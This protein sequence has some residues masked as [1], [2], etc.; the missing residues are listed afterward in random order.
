MATTAIRPTRPRSALRRMLARPQFRF[1]LAVLVPVLLWYAVFSFVPKLMALAMALLDF[2]LLA[3]LE[4]RFVGSRNF[5]V[6]LD[7]PLFWT[8]LANSLLYALGFF[9]VVVPLGLL[10]AAAL[11]RVARGRRVYEFAIFLPVVVSLV[12]VAL[13]FKWLLDEQVGLANYLLGIAGL[14]RSRFLTGES[15]ALATVIGVDVWKS[16]GFYVVILSAGMLNIPQAMYDAAMVDG[17]NAWH[18][19]RYVTLPLLGHTLAL[20]CVIAALHGLQV[21]TQVL[22]LP[23][24][25]G[26]PGRAT[27]VL[28]LFVYERAFADLKFGL[29]TAGAFSL[30][31]IVLVVTLIQLKLIRPTWSY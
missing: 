2:K 25:P 22:V 20:V 29:A 27:Y 28:N 17:A 21:F 6:M 26:G 8:A 18:R 30:F 10:V 16:L 14:P 19:F 3:P 7:N 4:S 15:S 13:L 11:T 12:A 23:A 24:N 1:G 5:E 31:L 9:A